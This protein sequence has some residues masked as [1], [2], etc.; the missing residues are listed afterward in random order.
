MAK[1]YASKRKQLHAVQQPSTNASNPVERLHLVNTNA[2]DPVK[3]LH[4]VNT[5]ASDPVEQL[6]MVKL[7]SRNASD[8]VEHLSTSNNTFETPGIDIETDPHYCKRNVDKREE[9]K[10]EHIRAL[11]YTNN[12]PQQFQ[13]VDYQ[14]FLQVR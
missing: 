13:G 9:R 3:R 2:S 10:E 11:T 5:N 6:H 4:S 12:I 7:P 1:S 14:C 8:P